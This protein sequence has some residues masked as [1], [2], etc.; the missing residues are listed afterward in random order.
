MAVIL[1]DNYILWKALT[2]NEFSRVSS[3]AVMRCREGA[4]E[5][6]RDDGSRENE[7]P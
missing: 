4:A 2:L 7:A 6:G 5:D 3:F 1:G